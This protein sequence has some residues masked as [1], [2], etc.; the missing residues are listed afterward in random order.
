MGKMALSEK[1]CIPC[2]GSIAPLTEEEARTHLQETPR[3]TLE[4]DGARIR[5]RWEFRNFA[6]AMEFARRVGELAAGQ[7]H[8]PDLSVGWGYCEVAFRTHRIRG[9]HE[10]D[11][12]M[13]AKVN[14]LEK[15]GS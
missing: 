7:G 3:W 10:N 9:L 11:F 5:R 15:D 1:T 14:A 4:E 13:A 12:I 2:K 6:S 8:H